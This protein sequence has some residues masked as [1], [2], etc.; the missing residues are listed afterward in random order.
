MFRLEQS[1]QVMFPHLIVGNSF[2]FSLTVIILKVID[3]FSAQIY[4]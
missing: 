2:L 4:I 3:I 1:D